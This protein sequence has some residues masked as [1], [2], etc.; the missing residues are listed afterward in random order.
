VNQVTAGT[1]AARYRRPTQRK[2]DAVMLL[3]AILPLLIGAAAP[4]PAAPPASGTWA[5]PVVGP[6]IGAFEPPETPFGAGHRGIDVAVPIG[7]VVAAPEGGVVAFAGPVGGHLFVTLDHGGGLTSTYSWL[8]VVLVRQGDVVAGGSPIARTGPGHPG[9]A[10]PH[11]HMGVRLDGTYLDPLAFL[12][13]VTLS[14]FIR[15][16]PLEAVAA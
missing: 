1:A 8:S 13:P 14:G 3:R 16:A 7:T 9:S 4:A 10:V 11:L 15:L 2:E 6:V 5:W 12:S